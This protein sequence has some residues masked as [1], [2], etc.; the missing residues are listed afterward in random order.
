MPDHFYGPDRNSAEIFLASGT[1]ILV[2]YGELLCQLEMSQSRGSVCFGDPAD[3]R[4]KAGRKEKGV[5]QC[6]RERP[7]AGMRRFVTLKG[8]EEPDP[9]ACRLVAYLAARMVLSGMDSVGIM[10]VAQGISPSGTPAEILSN[11]TFVAAMGVQGVVE[12][13]RVDGLWHPTVRLS[14]NVMVILLGGA[15]CIPVANQEVF[16]ELEADRNW[17]LDHPESKPK[18]RKRSAARSGVAGFVESIPV[19]TPKEICRGLEARGYVGQ[20]AARR[21]VALAAYRHVMRLRQIHLKGVPR[22]D[23]SGG[24]PSILAYG[25]TGSG[26]SFAM[27]LLFEDDLL[28]PTVI[29]DATSYSETGYIGREVSSM[30]TALLLKADGKAEVAQC[31]VIVVDEADKLAEDG[32]GG[33]TRVSRQGVQRSLLKLMDPGT[34]EIPADLNGYHYRRRMV[35]FRTHDLMWVACGAFSGLQSSG[36][37]TGRIGFSGEPCGHT[38]DRDAS[39]SA[40]DFQKYGL[41]PELVGRFAQW[42]RFD[43]LS[44]EQLAGILRHN[45]VEQRRRELRSHGVSLEVENAAIELIVEKAMARGTGARGIEAELTEA[46]EEASFE[47]YSDG[48]A[49]GIT[50]SARIGELTWDVSFRRAKKAD[51]PM[52]VEELN[53]KV[54]D[55]AVN[56]G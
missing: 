23:L 16:R 30:P 2:E 53:E 33:A 26:K 38:G 15:K 36:A 31:G 21:A 28:L 12:C 45:A 18:P 5:I 51:A 4:E 39:L 35:P 1:A 3:L 47:A 9:R 44:K 10:Q 42:V 24:G 49:K 56:A 25:P 11:R 14:G 34:V 8:E 13:G 54:E 22:E 50:V 55:L 7:K 19:A 37:S 48:R 20:E 46:L 27:R 40:S 43:P 41:L 52:T 29:L 6:L 17:R 32:T